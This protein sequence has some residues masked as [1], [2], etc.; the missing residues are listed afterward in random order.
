MIFLLA[1]LA[2]APAQADPWPAEVRT[3]EIVQQKDDKIAGLRWLTTLLEVEMVGPRGAMSPQVSMRGV[4]EERKDWNLLWGKEWIVKS[5]DPVKEFRID[6][7]LIQ[8][9]TPVD[10]VAIGPHGEVEHERFLLRVAKLSAYVEDV[11]KNPVKKDYLVGSMSLSSIGYSETRHP[12]FSMVALTGKIS[13]QRLLLPPRWDVGISTYLTLLPITD[14]RSDITA[15]F[16]GLNFRFGYVVPGI[17]DPWR[18]SILAGSYYTTMFVTNKTFGFRNMSGPQLFPNAQ[19]KL[20]NGDILG[21][22]LKFSPMMN[23]W[24]FL[25]LSKSREIAAGGSWS[26]VLEN[27]QPLSLSLDVANFTLTIN[28]IDISSTSVSVGAGYGLF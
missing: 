10:I 18:L 7:P 13:Y 23:G 6:V 17:K 28:N 12:D 21:F 3:A 2:A 15:R 4:L 5:A 27:G 9:D 1:L 20:E 16:F 8:D 25:S 19:R 11:K 26:H 22:Y 14:S 24:S